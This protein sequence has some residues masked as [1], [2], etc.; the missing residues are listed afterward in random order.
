MLMRVSLHSADRLG[1]F[2]NIA[3]GQRLRACVEVSVALASVQVSKVICF[4]V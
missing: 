3:E 4:R 1:F 2:G